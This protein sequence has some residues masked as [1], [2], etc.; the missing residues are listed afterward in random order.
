MFKR[1][2]FVQ[3]AGGTLWSAPS[4]EAPFSK[5]AASR[6]GSRVVVSFGP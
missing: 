4:N 3:T 2:L 1:M 6:K 5:N